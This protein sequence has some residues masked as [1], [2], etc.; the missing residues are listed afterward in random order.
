MMGFGAHSIT[1]VDRLLRFSAELPV[2]VEV[3]DSQEKM[4]MIMPTLDSMLK[5]GMVTLEPVK[6]IHYS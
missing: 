6:V 2:V 5:G 4:D 1:H 3:V